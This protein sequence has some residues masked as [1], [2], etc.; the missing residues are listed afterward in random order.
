MPPG[1][2]TVNGVII[3][4][5]E[6]KIKPTDDISSQVNVSAQIIES[7][8]ETIS[9][10]EIGWKMFWSAALKGKK[11][12]LVFELTTTGGAKHPFFLYYVHVM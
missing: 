7:G 6:G 1:D 4:A 8:S 5:F 9:G 10:T 3:K 11:L 12:T 2:E